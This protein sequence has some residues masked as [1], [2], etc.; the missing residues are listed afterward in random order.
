MHFITSFAKSLPLAGFLLAEADVQHAG[1]S[2]THMCAQRCH[3]LA[4]L[5]FS[6]TPALSYIN[7]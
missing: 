7:A 1:E 3:M 2:Q 4:A 5:C 6:L